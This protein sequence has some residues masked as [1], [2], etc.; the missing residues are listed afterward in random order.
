[1]RPLYT[2]DLVSMQADAPDIVGPD[3]MLADL[4][5]GF[6][7]RTDTVLHIETVI[8]S[9]DHSGDLAWE[10]GHVTFAKRHRDSLTAAS[11]FSRFKYITFWQ[12]G[13]DGQWRIRRDLAVPDPL[14][15][16]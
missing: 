12:R 16:S 7:T 14:P 1:M 10:S 5:G 6:L 2:A 15:P 4:A 13:S 11:R 3:A 9:L 8:A